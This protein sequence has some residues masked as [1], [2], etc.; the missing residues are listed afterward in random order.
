MGRGPYSGLF[1]AGCPFTT[2]LLTRFCPVLSIATHN[3]SVVKSLLL[4]P[5]W[6]ATQ[7][8]IHLCAWKDLCLGVLT[9]GCTLGIRLPST[10]SVLADVQ[11]V[12]RLV[13]PRLSLYFIS[14]AVRQFA[15]CF[16]ML[17]GAPKAFTENTWSVL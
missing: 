12:L 17:P 4:L 3:F 16:E 14:A 9:W 8:Q 2:S 10:P 7:A 15:Y 1:L 5:V 6:G 11:R 13:I